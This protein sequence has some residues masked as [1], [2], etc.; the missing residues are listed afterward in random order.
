MSITHVKAPTSRLHFGYARCDITPPVGIY[1]RMW[2]A[3]RHDQATGV[4]R[5]LQADIVIAEPLGGDASQRMVRV[6]LDF[7]LLDN[8]QTVRLV[9]PIAAS[10]N[11]A[12]DQVI[13]THSHSHSAGFFPANRY[14]M[15]GGDLIAPFLAEVNAKVAAAAAEAVA[16]LADATVTYAT[17]Q[18][19]MAAN[20]DYWDDD[21]QIYTT[22]FNPGQAAEN[23]AV[24]GRVTADDGSL[25]LLLVNYACHP[26]TLA[27]DNTLL[28]PD[29]VGAL[30]EVV[31]HEQNAPCCFYQA[32]C[33][34]L[35]PKDGFV[36]DT[37]VAD[38]NGKQ[39]G[40]AALSAL[41]SM[42]PPQTDFAYTGPVVSGATIG[43][44]GWSA[45]DQARQAETIAFAGGST[46]IPLDLIEIPT[47]AS[48]EQ[49]LERF[50][51]EQ[52]AADAKG[53]AVAARDFGARA[54]RCRRWLGRVA[55]LPQGKTFELNFSVHQ[56]GDAVWV[57][58]SAEPYSWLGSELRR[59]FPDLILFI[60]P[61]S[62]NAQ[63][64]YLLP[65]DRYGQGLYQEEPS[66][67]A[68]G[69][70]EALTAAISAKISA[71]TG[72]RAKG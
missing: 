55:L 14:T 31:E 53:D 9:A 71:T 43:T 13:V 58:C 12:P 24:V 39:V 4:H 67:L 23:T 48:L 11:V 5:A 64:A 54:E 7:V 51:V 63:V 27:W 10:A 28:S 21:K 36:G 16:T 41:Y 66:A 57:T 52:T 18:C 50:T 35:G 60:S 22:G 72:H 8:D 68:P 33:G 38:R 65:R 26:T 42:G 44:W 15:P 19:D 29:F 69:C 2:G 45:H 37:A 47:S 62:G 25:R 34:D 46:D 20:R 49:D 17:A 56:F 40:H 3:A 32:P 61:I 6:Q 70:L 59:R 1:H 30:R